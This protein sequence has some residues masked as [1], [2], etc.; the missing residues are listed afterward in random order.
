MIGGLKFKKD[1]KNGF[2]L[3]EL[4]VTITIFVI[5]TGVVL[6]SQSR[7]NSTIFLTNLAFTLMNLND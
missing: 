5:L 4:L 6:F 7:F 2:T 1:K 3:V